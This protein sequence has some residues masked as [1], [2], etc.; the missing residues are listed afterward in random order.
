MQALLLERDEE[1]KV[2][3]QKID[4]YKTKRAQ[5]RE[6]IQALEEQIKSQEEFTQPYSVYSSKGD[7]YYNDADQLDGDSVGVHTLPKVRSGHHATMAAVTA[8]GSNY[9]L[10][11]PTR[12]HKLQQEGVNLERRTSEPQ[13]ILPSGNGRRRSSSKTE[14]SSSLS[15]RQRPSSGRADQLAEQVVPVQTSEGERSMCIVRLERGAMQDGM[16]VVVKRSNGSFDRGVIKYIGGVSGN[17]EEF[18][19]VVLD[20]PRM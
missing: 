17:K 1:I 11:S 8:V 3:R 14:G 15:R 4:S 9:S 5:Y 10:P 6:H 7:H 12:Q 20:L 2:L 18:A 19:G 16:T 13:L